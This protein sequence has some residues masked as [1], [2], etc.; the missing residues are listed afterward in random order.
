M[1]IDADT[2]ISPTDDENAIRVEELI[3]QMEKS[4]VDRA[5]CWLQP[6]Y[7]RAIDDSL[8]YVYESVRTYPDKLLGFGWVDPHFGVEKGKATVKKCLDEYG[9]YG[10]KLNGA[11]NSYRIDDEKM[12][13]P[14]I[15]EIAKAGS[16]LA[17]HIGTDAYDYTHPY[18]AANIAQRFPE[19]TI[20]MVHM[21]G[22]SSPDLSSVCIEM[23]V[24][25]KNM[26]LIGS[27]V[28]YNSVVKAIQTLGASR[29]SF[30][31]DTPF[32]IMHADVCAYQAFL[33]DLF[34]AEDQRLVMGENI[35]RLLKL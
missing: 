9:F 7:M 32:S 34:T 35:C 10:V 6:P 31:S 16:I 14:I 21:G 30:G 4:R 1:I 24:K 26:H 2:H 12:A 15:E 25:H 22:V 11:Q 29:V 28:R 27:C 23:A 33:S 20:L 19:L 17:F 8:K 3:R 18:R 5:L 13:L